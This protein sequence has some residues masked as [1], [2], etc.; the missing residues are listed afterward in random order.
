[1]KKLYLLIL[2]CSTVI[3]GQSA[4]SSGLSFL[5][6]GFGARNMALADNGT[7]LSNDVTSIFYNPS[8]IGL[9]SSSEL[10]FM[11]NSW[12]QDIS[13]DVV[14]AKFKLF[15][16]PL[17]LGI[18]STRVKDIEIRTKPGEAEAL[19]NAQFFFVTAATGF[20]LDENLAAGFALKYIYESIYADDAGGY[21]ID[22]GFHY[23]TDIK[24]LSAGAAVRNIGSMNNLRNEPTKLP[25]EI[26]FGP[27]YTFE[28]NASD[29]I[30]N[31]GL[32]FQKYLSTDDF[33]IN[34]AAELV[35]SNM[36]SVRSGYRT[37][38]E[39]NGF[40]FGTGLKWGIVMFDYALTPFN[41]GLGTAHTI[42]LNVTI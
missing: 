11:H 26:R 42:S 15:G 41:E 24:G 20:K 30:L 25:T 4:G 38:Y 37:M 16:I 17:G 18:N 6:L 28:F 31:S 14:G 5:K 36:I 1:M 23:L 10:F 35:W 12:I 2:I 29:L 32:E 34:I 21:A 3:I 39:S 27:T 22:L 33:H 13:S 19:F 7:V 40:T 9:S 8:K